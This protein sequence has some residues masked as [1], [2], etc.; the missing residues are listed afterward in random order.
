[1]NGSAQ[2]LWNECVYISVYGILGNIWKIFWNGF[3]NSVQFL[4]GPLIIKRN[5]WKLYMLKYNILAT[6]IIK[7]KKVSTFFNIFSVLKRQGS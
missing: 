2:D 7:L 3:G 5:K 6:G 4:K 1:M